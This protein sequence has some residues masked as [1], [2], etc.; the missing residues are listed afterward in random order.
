LFEKIE[1]LL[2]ESQ[3]APETI[4]FLRGFL[5]AKPKRWTWI[6][7]HRCRG[8]TQAQIAAKEKCSKQ[9]VSKVLKKINKARSVNL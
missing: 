9:S 3:V 7:Y 6:F 4:H 5:A 1:Q 2:I 8:L